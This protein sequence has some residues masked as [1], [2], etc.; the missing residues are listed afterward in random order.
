MAAAAGQYLAFVDADDVMDPARIATAVGIM[1]SHDFVASVVTNF[2]HFDDESGIDPVDHFAAC[3]ELSAVLRT[4]ADA[5]LVLKPAAAATLLLTENVASSAALVRR[6]VIGVVGPYDETTPPCEDYD[7][8]Y[9][10]ARRFPIAVVPR[11]LLYKRRHASN[12]SDDTPRMLRAQIA[13]RRRMLAQAAD[14]HH[15]RLLRGMLAAYAGSLAYYYRDRDASLAVRC[16]LSEPRFPYAG[17]A[18]QIA[19]ILGAAAGRR[20]RRAPSL[21]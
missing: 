6:S 9:R 5:T 8:Q 14:P 20:I 13:L 12:L 15:R 16:A 4:A 3:P 17:N 21:R 10:I 7:F 1:Q 18:R 2:A 19:G 11:V